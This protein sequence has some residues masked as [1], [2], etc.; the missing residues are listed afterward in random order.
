MKTFAMVMIAALL[1][2][3]CTW[4]APQAN[5]TTYTP[6]VMSGN[7]SSPPANTTGTNATVQNN[8]TVA[9]QPLPPD[10]AVLIGDDVSV[11]Y[12]LYVND[13]LYDTNNATLANESGI[14]NPAKT[15]Q[16]L[17]FTVAFN[18]GMIEGFVI[19][20]IGMK[21]NSTQIFTVDPE[22]GY[23]PYDFSKVYTIQRYYDKN[24]SEV[25][26]RSYFDER[27]LNISNGTS[28]GSPYGIV[29]VQDFNDENVTILYTDLFA[30]GNESVFKVNGVPQRVAA[31]YT[32]VT[33]TMEY[34]LD[35][36]KSYLLPD[37]NTGALTKFR[38][39]DKTDQNITIDS[40]H[41]LANET[42]KFEV[43]LVNATLG[44]SRGVQVK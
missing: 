37:P 35:Y 4:Q 17:N 40:N 28:F 44:E 20:V 22:R 1:M 11:I 27:G 18:K 32:N 34:M 36:N 12:A 41:A 6:P 31:V 19:G 39:T 38:V 21:V 2:L 42:L 24:L 13:T 25:V 30:K 5:N 15:Y 23:G 26:P 16:P 29:S 33:A 14:Y 43:F 8:T 9:P 3:G 10:Y 7:A